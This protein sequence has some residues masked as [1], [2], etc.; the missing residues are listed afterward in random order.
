M[1]N[2]IEGRDRPLAERRPKPNSN[3][4]TQKVRIRTSIAPR[5]GPE[6]PAM[7]LVTVCRTPS[8]VGT[9][10]ASTCSRLAASS[11]PVCF[12][13]SNVVTAP[14]GTRLTRS[15][16]AAIGIG[17]RPI[18]QIRPDHTAITTTGVSGAQGFPDERA[19]RQGLCCKPAGDS[20]VAERPGH[21]WF[22]E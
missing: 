6:D 15:E 19:S 21:L 5:R 12:P 11:G 20:D 7:M 1:T 16:A 4:Q 10:C 18:N 22:T 8:S 3:A 17:R 13:M 9:R 14:P 2:A